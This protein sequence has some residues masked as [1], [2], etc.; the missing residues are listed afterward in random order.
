MKKIIKEKFDSKISNKV[1]FLHLIPNSENMH[2]K[3]NQRELNINP[4]K[5]LIRQRSDF[6][7]PRIAKHKKDN[8]NNNDEI[9]KTTMTFFNENNTI[10]NDK[11]EEKDKENLIT[12]GML[13]AKDLFK[14]K[15]RKLSVCSFMNK[16][17]GDK[18]LNENY[19][20]INDINIINNKYNLNLNLN[21]NK[22]TS[23]SNIFEGKK[24]KINGMLNKLYQYY[25][26]ETKKNI[27][28]NNEYNHSNNYRNN[29]SDYDTFENKKT[30]KC[31]NSDSGNNTIEKIKSTYEDESNTFL[32]KLNNYNIQTKREKEFDITKFI[33]ERSSLSEVNR[34]NK[35]ILKTNK[36]ISLQCLLSQLRKDL[37][38]KKILYK[39][40]DK[41]V[42]ELEKD[43]TYKKVKELEDNIVKILKKN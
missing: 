6:D 3:L 27:P 28:K 24:Y 35:Q 15:S 2:F 11:N 17:P 43:P 23:T 36:R 32:T 9:E 14:N 22:N 10:S 29:S 1:P 26:S 40:I 7:L 19:K 31:E 37:T 12:S 34:Y 33:Q 4:K 38:L 41:S 39:Y 8:K 25:S 42:Y 30:T 16:L 21:D 20:I 18:S 13:K 5:K